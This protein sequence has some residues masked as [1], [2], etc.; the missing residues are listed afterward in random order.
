M[1]LTPDERPILLCRV[2]CPPS[3]QKELDD[4]SPWHFDDFGRHPAVMAVSSYRVLR[5]FD[6]ENGLPSAFN[7]SQATRWIPYVVTDIASMHAWIGS[8][9]VTGGL[10]EPT[11]ERENKY[12]SIAGEPFNG[13]MMSVSQVRGAR[14]TDHVGA[15]GIVVERFEVGPRQEAEFD[16]WLDGPHLAGYEALS[17]WKRL[18]T[19]KGDRSAPAK[20]PWTRYL[21]KGNRMIWLELEEG[22]DP[23]GVVR[24]EA[25]RE[26]LRASLR[27]DAVLP[28]VTREAAENFILRDVSRIVDTSVTGAAA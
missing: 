18:R 15:G 14:G 6:P 17:G 25:Y 20:F 12:P 19:F 3:L 22:I 24:S 11:L 13:T 5:D 26:L 28:Y 10:D 4:W 7:L 1:A 27:W 9:I 23:K 8:P 2:D 21:G 16:A